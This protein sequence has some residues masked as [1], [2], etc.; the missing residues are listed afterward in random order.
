MRY[1]TL[2]FNKS[3]L[4]ED[5]KRYWGLAVL[6]FLALFFT[7][8]MQIMLRLS[9]TTNNNTYIVKRFLEIRG[10][11]IQILYSIVF[12]I[13][14][15][16]LIFRYLHQNKSATMM[17]AFPITRQELFHSHNITGFILLTLPIL[18]NAL[19]LVTLMFVYNDGSELFTKVYTSSNILIWLGKTVVVDIV[20]YL[21]AVF[22]AMITG[23]SLIQG[24]LSFIFLF[25][26][27][28]LVSLLLMNFDQLIYGFTVNQNLLEG[29]VIKAIPLTAMLDNVAMN[30]GIVTWYIILSLVLYISGYH[31][32]N[33]RQLE[34]AS[35]P[36]VFNI[37]KP[38]FKY[39]V[40]FCAMVLGGAYFYSIKRYE[41][42]LYIGYII[43]GYLGYLIAEMLIQKSIWVFKNIKGLAVY[44]MVIFIIFMGINFDV[45]GYEKRI[46]DL[47][48][49]EN[50]Y[51]GYSL[52]GYWNEDEKG[53]EDS[54]NIKNIQKLHEELIRNKEIFSKINENQQTRNI[55]IAYELKNGKVV[56]REYSVPIEF[57]ERNNTIGKIYESKEYKINHYEIFNLDESIIDYA[58]LYSYDVPIPNKNI[59]LIDIDE[60]NEMIEII[61]LDILDETYEEYIDD[62]KP[63]A[64]IRFQ[65]KKAEDLTGIEDKEEYMEKVE[66][67]ISVS[68]KRSY[69]H[70]S[71]W[72]KDKGYYERVRLMP[73]EINYIVVQEIDKDMAEKEIHRTIDI[74]EFSKSKKRIEI[75][76]KDKIEE[77]LWKYEENWPENK[78][79]IIG[80]YLNN[81]ND[82]IGWLEEENTP[83]Y[84]KDS[85]K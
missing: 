58:E 48:N 30:I 53:L 38:I 51:Y 62:T 64:N 74:S 35:D 75:K 1:K 73:E 46:P 45:F 14:L 80:F 50:A 5:L 32:Y 23:I 81:G 52:Y 16:M 4:F 31:F 66:N 49:V 72:L 44:L 67:R 54:E 27:M 25:L 71:K 65:Y 2:F 59:K 20:I 15:A 39:G 47:D 70:L 84:I 37:L 28:G 85:L 69:S 56:A 76:D 19:I 21:I 60:I 79:Y 10:S 29:Y 78:K 11:E 63:W 41:I 13:I 36:I 55:G 3:I 7:G 77:I 9:N 26:P 40:T 6:Y 12:S 22:T 82:F 18:L 68:W 61:K 43:G 42:W 8:P 83:E 34:S 57:I 33:K 17:H 24:I